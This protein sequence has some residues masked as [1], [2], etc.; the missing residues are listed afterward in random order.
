MDPEGDDFEKDVCGVGTTQVFGLHLFPKV[1][2]LVK[3]G[4]L[5]VVRG[6]SDRV[7]TA[8]RGGVAALVKLPT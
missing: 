5:S 4:P 2:L 8:L 3:H 1:G 6:V 7:L